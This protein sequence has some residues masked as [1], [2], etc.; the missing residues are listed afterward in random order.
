MKICIADVGD[1]ELSELLGCLI[2]VEEI[3]CQL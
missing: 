3:K 1:G 2:D